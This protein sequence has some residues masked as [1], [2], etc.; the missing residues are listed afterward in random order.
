MIQRGREEITGEIQRKMGDERERKGTS[1]S[2]TDMRA[3]SQFNPIIN[4]RD[5]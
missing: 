2:T 1:K 5:K 3:G 4:G